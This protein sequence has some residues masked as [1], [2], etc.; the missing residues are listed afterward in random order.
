MFDTMGYEAV[1]GLMGVLDGPS[2]IELPVIDIE[3]LNDIPESFDPKEKWP[4]C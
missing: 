1:K 3:P 2:P 4:S